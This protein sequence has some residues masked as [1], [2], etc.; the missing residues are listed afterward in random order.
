MNAEEISQLTGTFEALANPL[1]L[2]LLR[3]LSQPAFSRD[4]VRD[5]GLTR[6]GLRRH[7]DVLAAAGL[8][9]EI[10]SRRGALPARAYIASPT[11]LFVFK[12]NVASLALPVDP[13]MLGPFPTRETPGSVRGPKTA[14]PGLLLVHGDVPGR[15]FPL[16]GASH[17]VG[18][19][20][21]G[22]IS[23]PYDPFASARHAHLH[24]DGAAWYITDLHSRNGTALNFER[25]PPGTTREIVSG[26]V[27]S[28]GRSRLVFRE[29]R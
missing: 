2:D 7:L 20:S 15:W 18:R 1:R 14:G 29:G 10:R 13:A 3:R 12:E 28:V 6:Q 26:D 25:M 16:V 17:V 27:L 24:R 23:L 22:G 9:E 19:D 8:I 4:L 11:G 5:M 21:R